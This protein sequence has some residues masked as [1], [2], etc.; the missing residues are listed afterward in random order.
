M[1][2][3]LFLLVF[4]PLVSF[5][6]DYLAFVG[7]KSYRSSEGFTFDNKYDDVLISF[8]KT[9][10]GNAIYLK[11]NYIYSDNPKIT[12]KLTLYLANG[13][14]IISESASVT[15]YADKDCISLY[16]LKES[17]IS[18]LKE[19]DLVR[20]RFT[21]TDP[22]MQMMGGEGDINRYASSDEDTSEA[23]KDF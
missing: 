4:I 21:I 18:A 5:S 6:Q 17:D 2:K 23:L 12:K 9:D 10:E 13:G 15:D 11:T 8:V 3:L 20:V 22:N 16:P 19:H 1:K 7:D 14:V